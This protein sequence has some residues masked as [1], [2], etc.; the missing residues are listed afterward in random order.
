M[1]TKE[2]QTHMVQ[3]LHSK[4][5]TQKTKLLV[6]V[7]QTLR[8][9]YKKG[10]R[11]KL[12]WHTQS[13]LTL[14]CP[15]RKTKT[16]LSLWT[17]FKTKTAREAYRW[18][19]EKLLLKVWPKKGMSSRYKTWW[20]RRTRR[21]VRSRWT[22]I[23]STSLTKGF[24]PHSSSTTTKHTTAATKLSTNTSKINLVKIKTSN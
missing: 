20:L 23:R 18:I 22:L 3:F 15:P 13:K 6:P 19:L 21:T 11:F 14:L 17:C 2:L 1:F 7:K 4:G 12:T 16:S 5:F 10:K 24:K 8:L 9:I